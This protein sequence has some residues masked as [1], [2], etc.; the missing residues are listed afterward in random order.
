MNAELLI[1]PKYLTKGG[2]SMF[3]TIFSKQCSEIEK[4]SKVIYIPVNLIRPNP[5]QPRKNFNRL[6]LEDLCESIKTYG[7]IQPITVRKTTDIFF[8]L[9]AG[10]RRLRASKIIG[11]KEI[12]AIVIEIDDDNAAI[13]AVVENSQREDLHFL[14]EAEAYHN[15]LNIHK[16]TQEELSKKIG[17]SSS[18]I[19]NK[20]RL[21]RLS[22]LIR[23]AIIENGLSERQA[24]S[25]LKLHDENVQMKIVKI[26]LER[27]LNTSKTEELVERTI[28][29][30]IQTKKGKKMLRG[31]YKDLRIFVNT[32][33]SYRNDEEFRFKSSSLAKRQ[34]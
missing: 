2:S 30:A 3:K 9:V 23:K 1:P 14:E 27:G 11:M 15:L 33:K 25:L 4:K 7:L 32:I 6:T 16:I 17:K 22:S 13:L 18:T 29:R 5:Y 31:A 19:S 24:R 34:R 21:L 12:P 10:E 26:I 28:E 8:E 20:I